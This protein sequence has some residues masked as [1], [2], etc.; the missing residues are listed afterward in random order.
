MLAHARCD[1]RLDPREAQLE[2]LR[3]AHRQR[4]RHR[5]RV[6]AA[7]Q[8]VDDRAARIPEPEHL[9]HLVEGL[10]RG[11]VTGGAELADPLVDP[12]GRRRDDDAREVRIDILGGLEARH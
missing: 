12:L 10:A 5:A 11:V 2:R 9:A 6:A 8:A 4:E 7:R 1:L 3:V